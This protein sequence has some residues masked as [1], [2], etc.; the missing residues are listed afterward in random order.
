MTVAGD[1][2]PAAVA[3]P[4]AVLDFW[5]GDPP[6][7]ALR[8]EWFAKDDAFDAAIARRFG[9]TIDAAIG[10]AIDDWHARSDRAA[11]ARIVVLD[12]FTRN[13]HRGTP[14]AFAGDA[15]AL[16]AARDLVDT[17]RDRHL[18]PLER[19]FVYLPFEHA[20]DAAAQRRAVALF[21]ALADEAPALADA[22]DWAVKHQ[23]VI[24]R[25]GRFP[26]RNAIVGRESTAEE[27][28]FLRQPGSSF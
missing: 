6:P 7:A 27:I 26:H 1:A 20:E 5:F 15:R 4:Q 14:R 24:D 10:G 17:G 11:L 13:A 22:V 18:A 16:A 8:R 9:A 28:E 21:T 3:D 2:A 12:Q 25:F 19:W 23:R